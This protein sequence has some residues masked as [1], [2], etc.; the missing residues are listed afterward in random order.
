LG[1]NDVC[2]EYCGER[3]NTN[4]LDYWIWGYVISIFLRNTFQF[5]LRKAKP[6]FIEMEIGWLFVEQAH[7][8]V[9]LAI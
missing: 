1:N 8:Y 7:R 6:M 9:L 3:N 2:C 5:L 4:L